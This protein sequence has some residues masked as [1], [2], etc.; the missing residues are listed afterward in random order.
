MQLR[1]AGGAARGRLLS[2][3]KGLSTRPTPAGVREAL[4][5][6][7]RDRLPGA[8]VLDLF[9]G[10]GT[11][12]LELLSQGAASALFVERDRTAWGCLR[13]NVALLGYDDRCEVWCATV[14]GALHTLADPPRQ[15]ELVFADPPYERDLAI[16]T[17]A[18]L[19][20][21]PALLAPGGLAVLQH[22]KREPLAE[23]TGRLRR[24]RQRVTGD[25]VL[26]FYEESDG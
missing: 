13:R 2:S 25:T 21:Q 14:A 18:R 19:A 6:I 3:G 24:T 11:C 17:L 10:Y 4:A 7:L 26:S 9:A 16:D 1:I 8:R 15:F 20:A 12:G 22:S 5:N 23:S